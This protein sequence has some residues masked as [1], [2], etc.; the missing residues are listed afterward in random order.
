MN[1]IEKYGTMLIATIGAISGGFAIYNDYTASEFRKPIDLRVATVVSY[2]SHIESASKRGD[3]DE[4][5]RVRIEYEKYEEAWRNNQKLA[6]LTDAVTNLVSLEL[7]PEDSARIVEILQTDTYVASDNVEPVTI[8]SAYLATGDYK[9][10]IKYFKFAAIKEPK[11]P[12]IYALRSLALQG[13]AQTVSAGLERDNLIKEAQFFST[14]ASNKGVDENL[15]QSI[16]SE[17]R[18]INVGLTR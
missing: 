16:S 12:N 10:A 6:S 14:E 2:N 13:K 11:N 7:R 8:G 18:V 17:L 3:K 9:N 5:L 15:M 4:A 1:N